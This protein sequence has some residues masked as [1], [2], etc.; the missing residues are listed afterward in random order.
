[1]AFNGSPSGAI[2]AYLRKGASAAIYVNTEN[3][4]IDTPHVGRA[5][6]VTSEPNGVH[7]FGKPL[8]IKFRINHKRPVEKA[9]LSFQIVNQFQQPAVYAWAFYPEVAFGTKDEYTILTC[10]FPSLRLNIG[11]FYL[12]ANLSGPPGAE[13]YERLDGICRFE[14]VQSDETR[15]WGWHPEDCTYHEQW[16]WTVEDRYDGA[17]VGIIP[18]KAR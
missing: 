17:S 14:V 9:C 11:Q 8:K 12:R 13:V 7:R 4:A 15:L 1:V 2:G 6:V 3:G 5:E 10:K 18:A 16:D